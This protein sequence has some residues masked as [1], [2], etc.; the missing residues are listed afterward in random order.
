MSILDIKHP[1][2]RYQKRNAPATMAERAKSQRK[3]D[4]DDKKASLQA[5]K[6][7]S[8]ASASSLPAKKQA[9][10]ASLQQV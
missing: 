8:A 9:Q 6:K 4:S 1:I 3:A 5:F 2:G 7:T 10:S